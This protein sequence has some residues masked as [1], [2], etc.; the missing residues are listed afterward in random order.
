MT[1]SHS[2]SSADIVDALA[3]TIWLSGFERAFSRTPT[4]PWENQ[5]E[6]AKAPH[7][8]TARKIIEAGFVTGTPAQPAFDRA[9]LTKLVLE[10]QQCGVGDRDEAGTFRKIF[11]DDESLSAYDKHGECDCRKTVDAILAAQPLAAPVETDAISDWVSSRLADAVARS[12]A[13]SAGAALRIAR[14]YLVEEAESGSVWTGSCPCQPF[15][16]AGAQRGFDDERHLWPVWRELIARAR[17]AIVFGEQVASATEWLGLVRGDLE[18]MEYAVGAMPIQAASAGADHLRDRYWFVADADHARSQGR[19]L[20][21]ERAGERAAGANGMADAD[22]PGPG[23]ERQQRGRQLRGAGCDP[24]PCDCSDV[25]FSDCGGR[26]QGQQ[27]TAPARHGSAAVTTGGDLEWVI[28]ADGKAR[29]VKPG[30]RLLAHG[31]PNRVGLLR[32]FGNAIDPR[33]A[34]AFILLGTEK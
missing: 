18:A 31:I 1:N 29:R 7:I 16:L 26:S 24:E 21:P 15:S 32:G 11:C 19:G 6:S 3:K 23:E 8:N 17:P 2:P 28:G 25:G 22:E 9:T 10:T 13:G 20:L 34:A 27:T 12:S 4:D 30:I 5:A 33:P 14:A